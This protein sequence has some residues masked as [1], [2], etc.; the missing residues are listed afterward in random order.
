MG[1]E[2]ARRTDGRTDGRSGWRRRRRGGGGLPWKRP[3]TAKEERPKFATEKDTPLSSLQGHRKRIENG[4]TNGDDSNK[5]SVQEDVLAG[6]T[7][8]DDNLIQ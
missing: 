3:Y 2:G 7:N 6:Q 8:K 1:A 5:A 4:Q